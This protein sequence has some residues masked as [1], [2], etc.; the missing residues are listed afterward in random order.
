MSRSRRY[1][2]PGTDRMKGTPKS[3]LMRMGK[4]ASPDRIGRRLLKT[5]CRPTTRR[6]ER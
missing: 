5:L 1:I 3:R 6:V 2:K 4:D